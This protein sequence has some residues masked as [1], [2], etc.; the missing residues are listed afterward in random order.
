MPSTCR[1]VTL[2]RTPLNKDIQTGDDKQVIHYISPMYKKCRVKVYLS[3]IIVELKI[4]KVG[5]NQYHAHHRLEIILLEIPSQSKGLANRARQGFQIKSI[6]SSLRASNLGIW[7]AGRPL[8]TP[9][10]ESY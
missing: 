4:T 1:I 9:L 5:S 8:A 6:F 3:C 10:S 2:T 7:P